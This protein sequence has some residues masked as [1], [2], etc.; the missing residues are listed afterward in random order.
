MESVRADGQAVPVSEVTGVVRSCPV[1]RPSVRSFL[2][3]VA[4]PRLAWGDATT[5]LVA[6]GAA[7][8]ITADGR[9]RFTAVKQAADGLFDGLQ[10]GDAIVDA[11]RPRLFGGFAFHENHADPDGDD[12]WHGYPGAQFVLPEI[13]VS[14]STDGAWLTAAATGVDAADR[15]ATTLQRWQNRLDA[16]P[17]MGSAGPP[18]ITRRHPTPSKDGW[19]EQ[20]RSAIDQVNHG[21][22]QKVVLAQSLTVDLEQTVDV[23]DALSRLSETYPGCYRFLFEP[24]VGSTFFGAT[25]ERLVSLDGRTVRTEALAGSTGRGETPEEDEWLASELRDSEKDVHEHELVADA[26][27]DQLAPLATD[28]ETGSRTVRRLDTVQHLQTPIQAELTADTHILSL[29]EALHPTPAVGGL[30][31]DI[32]LRTIRETEAFDRGWY[33]APIGWLDADGDGTFAVAIRSALAGTQSATLFAGA[34]IVAD[35]NPD[36]EWDELQLK[37]GPMLDELA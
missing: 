15:A 1:E 19:R 7:A 13:Q 8:V 23:P 20:V 30:P 34:G 29:V 37:Y 17:D 10:T 32:A 36:E 33:A 26:I 28:I 31:P 2:Q 22:L 25:P 3:T 9:D 5:T 27:G 11:A 12:I 35:S 18:G 14:I 16:L 24:A 6:G 4:R 21:T